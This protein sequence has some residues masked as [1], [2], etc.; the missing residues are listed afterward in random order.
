MEFGAKKSI[1]AFK[2]MHNTDTL[3]VVKSPKTGKLF[4]SANGKTVAAVSKNYDSSKPKE[5][6]ELV[7]ESGSI[8]CL[9]NIAQ[10]NTVET[11]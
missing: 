6:V 7:T 5:F 8:W 11:L 2:D 1:S 3:E 9:H 4:V 10:N